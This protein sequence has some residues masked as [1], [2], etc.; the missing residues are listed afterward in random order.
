MIFS[1]HFFQAS[2]FYATSLM[3]TSYIAQLSYITYI[4]TYIIIFIQCLMSTSKVVV[5]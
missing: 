5:M 4:H 3:F 1:S 2:N